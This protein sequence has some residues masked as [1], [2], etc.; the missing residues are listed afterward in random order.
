MGPLSGANLRAVVH[1]TV[2]THTHTH[3]HTH[4]HARTHTHTHAHTHTHTHTRTH[5]HPPRYGYQKA[6]NVVNLDLL[7]LV[8]AVVFLVCYTVVTLLSHFITLW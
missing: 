7:F 8:R 5:T 6:N 1:Q 2:H 4:A 3:T